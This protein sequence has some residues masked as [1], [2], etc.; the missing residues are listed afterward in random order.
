ML[1][2]R[3]QTRVQFV[4]V[5]YSLSGGGE[6]LGVP[7]VEED[8]NPARGRQRLPVA[9]RR[10]MRCVDRSR[11]GKRYDPDV[12]WIHPCGEGIGGLAP[13][14]TLDTGNED[15]HRATLRLREIVLGIEQRLTQTWLIAFIR[16]LGELVADFCG[17]EHGRANPRRV[18]VAETGATRHRRE[19]CLS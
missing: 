17:F 6:R 12:P 15:Q 7:A 5:R 9:P 2:D 10:R 1:S 14:R 13:T 4:V 8:T 19:R 18:S 11:L 3:V 16:S